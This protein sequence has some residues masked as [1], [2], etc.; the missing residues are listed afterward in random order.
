MCASVQP[1]EKVGTDLMDGSPLEF[2]AYFEHLHPRLFAAL[3]MTTGSRHEAEE[4][5]QDAFLKV[6][7]RWDR[8]SLMD[9]PTSYLFTTAMNLFRKRYRRTQFA[10]KLPIPKPEH[11]DAFATV[12]DRDELV[13]ALRDLTPKQ[14]AAIVLTAILDIPSPEAARILG[15]KDSTVRVLAGKA[16]AQL[17]LTVG[18]DR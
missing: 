5:A 15:I 10:A 11:D 7:E 2:D 6:L 4:I 18:E 9:D 16:R 3:C 17:R 8:V 14:R 13:R 12:N 1:V